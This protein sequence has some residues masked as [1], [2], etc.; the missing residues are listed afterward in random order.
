MDQY[1][2]NFQRIYDERFQT[3]YGFWHHER[4]DKTEDIVVNWKEGK[5]TTGRM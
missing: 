2:E 4:P 3:K 1:F 5:V